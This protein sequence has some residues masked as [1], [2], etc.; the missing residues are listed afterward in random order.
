MDGVRTIVQLVMDYLLGVRCCVQCPSCVYTDLLDGN[1][2][3]EGD[4]LGR[5]D[6]VYGSIE[7]S[8]SA[9]SLHVHLVFAS[10]Y[11]F[12]YIIIA[13]SSRVTTLIS[14]LCQV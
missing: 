6:S 2:M 8:K 4:I 9:G 1:T 3:S 12:A 14:R 7:V 5:V 11:P 13:R 10:M